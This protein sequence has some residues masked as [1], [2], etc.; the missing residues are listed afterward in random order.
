MNLVVA[1]RRITARAEAM[2]EDLL[3][4]RKDWL[5]HIVGADRA[6]GTLLC[7]TSGT[8][9]GRC[10]LNDVVAGSQDCILSPVAVT[11]AFGCRDGDGQS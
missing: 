2:R 5:E 3:E 7:G 1:D 4:T 9:S 11:R 6:S 8:I 10:C